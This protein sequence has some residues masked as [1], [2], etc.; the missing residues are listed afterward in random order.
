MTVIRSSCGIAAFACAAILFAGR[1]ADCDDIP[2]LLKEGMARIHVSR[3]DTSLCV[4]TDASYVIRN[5]KTTERYLDVIT[6]ATGCSPGKGNLLLFHRPTTYVLKIAMFNKKTRECAVVD[7]DSARAFLR[8]P[9][10]LAFER[11]NDDGA[12][13]TIQS[14]MGMS[15]AFAITGIAYQWAAGAPYDFMKCAE[16][17]NHLCPGITSGYF[18]AKYIQ[19]F[20]PPGVNDSYTYISCPPWCKDD[21]IQMLMDLTPGKHGM[22]VQALSDEQLKRIADPNAAGIMLLRHGKR[23]GATALIV[24]F[25][26]NIANELGGLKKFTGRQ[27][28]LA[29]LTG[30]IP[31]YA[32]PERFVK[33]LQTREIDDD[34]ADSLG[35]AGINPY[36]VLGF[37]K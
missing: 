10:S 28:T 4:L 25:D 35:R 27:A 14:V 32:A 17:H 26:Q 22:Y 21:G 9:V 30:L 12:W 11:L 37:M 15:D 18:I 31:F 2:R 5:G 6:E 19:K 36:E 20:H 24:S 29:V 34:T 16:L 1:T 7:A 3:G 8:G 13:E 23:G 33:V